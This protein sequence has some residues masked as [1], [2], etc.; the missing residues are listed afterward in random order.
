MDTSVLRIGRDYIVTYYGYL[1]L[2][3]QEGLYCDILWIPQSMR[4]ER[5]YNYDILL[6][7]L[8]HRGSGGNWS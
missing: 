1:G 5:D 3:D 8:G 6:G 4:T 7:Y 2:E